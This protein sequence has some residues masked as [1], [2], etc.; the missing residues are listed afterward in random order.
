VSGLK[1]TIVKQSKV[2]KEAEWHHWKKV[3]VEGMAGNLQLPLDDE[4]S[5]DARENG[6]HFKACAHCTAVLDGTR[7]VLGLVVTEG[8]FTR[9]LRVHKR[10][11]RS[12]QKLRDLRPGRGICSGRNGSSK[13]WV[14]HVHP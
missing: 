2:K 5:P 9:A 7:N 4:I 8:C 1:D 10:L 12:F 13:V 3:C 11:S 6:R 14:I